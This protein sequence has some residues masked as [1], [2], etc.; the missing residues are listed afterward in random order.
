M[1]PMTGAAIVSICCSTEV[2]NTFTKA[3]YVVLSTIAVLM[4]TALFVTTLVHTFM[5]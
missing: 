3:L 1:F 2:D 5:L 4:M